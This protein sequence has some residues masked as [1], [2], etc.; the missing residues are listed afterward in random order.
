M[1]VQISFKWAQS[2][3]KSLI[4]AEEFKMWIFFFLRWPEWMCVHCGWQ[5]DDRRRKIVSDRRENC[6]KLCG[7]NSRTQ[8]CISTR[9]IWP[10]GSFCLRC[11]P[12]ALSNPK[13]L[14]LLL[15]FALVFCSALSQPEVNIAAASREWVVV[16]FQLN[17]E[18]AS[19]VCVVL[20]PPSFESPSL[21]SKISALTVCRASANAYSVPSESSSA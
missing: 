5:Q 7:C 4:K 3:N 18:F 15:A 20:L 21:L 9:L 1:K 13:L 2:Q 11:P 6:L 10:L 8:W 17:R 19:S 12:L 14:L 16:Q